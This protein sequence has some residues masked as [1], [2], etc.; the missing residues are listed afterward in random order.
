MQ[1]HR[2][3]RRSSL[4]PPVASL[5]SGSP[6][7]SGSE[8]ALFIPER[9]LDQLVVAPVPVSLSPV[10]WRLG[11]KTGQGRFFDIVDEMKG[12]VG[13]GLRFMAY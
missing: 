5:T 8:I 12:H 13:G 6:V 11:P 2:T 4:L 1:F 7:K 9:G 10:H 3:G